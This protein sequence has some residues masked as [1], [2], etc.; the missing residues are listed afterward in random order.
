MR[1]FIQSLCLFTLVA[2]VAACA[3]RQGENKKKKIQ[4]FMAEFQTSLKAGKYEALKY[5]DTNQSRDALLSALD[6]LQNSDTSAV[7]CMPDFN[8][9]TMTAGDDWTNKTANGEVMVVTIPTSFSPTV[10][11]G[12]P[13]GAA[14]LVFWVV[15]REGG[16]KVCMIEANDLYAMYTSIKH[17]IQYAADKEEE[18]KRRKHIY[19]VAKKLEE[20]YD[21]VIWY[22]RYGSKAYFYVISGTWDEGYLYP[23]SKTAKPNYKMG[24]IDD[25]E[26]V[27][28]PIEYELIGTLGYEVENT[29]EVKGPDGY[30]YFSLLG[31]T[32]VTPEYN[33][34]IPYP[35]FNGWIVQHSG[36]FGWIGDNKAYLP[37]FPTTKIE[38]YV[39]NYTFIPEALTINETNYSL[40]ESPREE[41]AGTGAFIAPSYWVWLGLSQPVRFGL[42]T[43]HTD[44]P[45][46]GWT[47]YTE[48]SQSVFEK[49]GDQ[50]NLLVVHF[51][52]RYLEGREEFY[53]TNKVMFTDNTMATLVEDNEVYGNDIEIKKI[54]ND[55][56]ELRSTQSQTDMMDGSQSEWTTYKYYQ[57]TAPGVVTRLESTRTY[58]QTEFAYLDSTY[59]QGT[60]NH[61]NEETETKETYYFLPLEVLETMREQILVAN[62]LTV[63]PGNPRL[64]GRNELNKFASEKD[65]HNVN[66]LARMIV[67]S[68]PDGDV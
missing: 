26:K 36:Q 2:G 61:W 38:A 39:S 41:G 67:L 64:Y 22:T 7:K 59:L 12:N 47:E 25:D 49:L 53:E 24:L 3:L 51:K 14:N 8:A 32:L 27:I 44:A 66:F 42:T 10:P 19:E 1:A 50:I 5:F 52:E 30:G 6:I 17:D 37:G 9:M 13:G 43:T 35:E 31:D 18:L 28:V 55:I 65:W 4:V 58:P 23:E 54:G 48:M 34:V 40:L 60:F 11:S 63:E 33:H 15:E 68:Y 46:G 57:I 62:G 45:I 56:I 29:V 20:K 21:S 16:F